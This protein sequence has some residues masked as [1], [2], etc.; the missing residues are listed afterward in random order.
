MATIKQRLKKLENA[1]QPSAFNLIIMIQY[2]DET[3]LECIKRHGHD[4]S[5]KYMN[6][7]HIKQYDD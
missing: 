3:D 5:Y 1:M 6:Y 2:N 4:P 7:V